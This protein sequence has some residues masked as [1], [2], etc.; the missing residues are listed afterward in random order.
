MLEYFIKEYNIEVRECSFEDIIEIDTFS[1]LKKLDR[2]YA[3]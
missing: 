2:T 1:D 3:V